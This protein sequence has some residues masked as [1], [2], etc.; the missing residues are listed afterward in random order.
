[1]PV[2]IESVEEFA[3]ADPRDRSLVDDVRRLV[4]TGRTLA[5][6]EIA[7]QKARAGYAGAQAKVIAI[8]GALA[9]VLVFFAL[10][11]LTFG[12]ILGLSAYV[13]PFGATAIVVGTLLVIA[14]VLL[15]M[16][17]SRSKRMISALSD[18]PEA[19]S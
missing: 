16:V 17:Q 4:E 15:L 3:S 1:M 10:M 18:R 13:G 5:E 8:Q 19:K 6:A 7:Y 11:G 12:L 9:A 2:A 14:F